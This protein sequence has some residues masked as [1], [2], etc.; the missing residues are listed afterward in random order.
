MVQSYQL[1]DLIPI[2]CSIRMG[3]H[4]PPYGRGDG[5]FKKKRRTT[6]CANEVVAKQRRV[7]PTISAATE[8]I[9]PKTRPIFARCPPGICANGMIM[10]VANGADTPKTMAI[11]RAS[12]LGA[13]SNRFLKSHQAAAPLGMIAADAPSKPSTKLEVCKP[14]LGVNMIAPK[15]T[16][17]RDAKKLDLRSDLFILI[18]INLLRK[19]SNI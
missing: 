14:K 5:E 8:P 15:P 13:C 7:T 19:E 18:F 12:I 16:A 2:T 17:I 4:E 1:L 6:H 10:N 11:T 3:G 9:N